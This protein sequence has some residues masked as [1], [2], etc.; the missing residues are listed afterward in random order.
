M[1]RLLALLV[2]LAMLL[3]GTPRAVVVAR[4]Q[5]AAI[6]ATPAAIPGFT[7][8]RNDAV[9]QFPDGITFSID[10][11][12]S[13]PIA[14]VELLYHAPGIETLSM[15]VPPITPGETRLTVEHPVDL[16][17][18]QLPPG[19]DVIY[20]WRIIDAEGNVTQ[21]DEQTL[22]WEDNRYDWTE[23]AGPRV[24]VYAY[25]ASPEFQQAILDSAERT[26]DKLN[27]AYGFLPTQPIR[28][29]AYATKD[30]L[31]GAL[32]PN[33]EPWIAGEAQP[34]LFLIRAILP[35]D[36]L[37][38]VDRVV[39]HEITHQVSYQV[40]KN[41]FNYPPLWLNEG[42]AV[43]WQETGRDRFYTHALQIAKDGNVPPLRTLNGDFAYDSEGALGSYAL[44]LSAVIYILDTYG[45]EGMANLLNVFREGITYDDA[46]EQG[47]GVSFDELDAGWHAYIK[48]KA[49]TL[50][51]SGS[52]RFGDTEPPQNTP[53]GS[54][55]EF[56]ATSAG[57]LILGLV[58]LIALAAGVI[59]R[60]RRKPATADDDEADDLSPGPRWRDWPESV[61]LPGRQAR[62]PSHP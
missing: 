7:I 25:D 21:T 13:T 20:S 41:P 53:G 22:L 30:D 58:V 45:D 48:E 2:I 44:S 28:I 1:N 35:P 39:P 15:E 36:D 38:E 49:D 3:G 4:A 23:L 52:T 9:S 43:Y 12:S 31:Y 18:G 33:S 6:V 51:A 37:R 46:I 34:S 14:R 24:T 59:S 50:L 10:A 26:I 17:S 55:W 11:E 60:L 27:N 54:L 16:R 29:W 8:L 5:D 56:L 47:L 62:L 57:S 61:E 40:T 19:I 32:A 42:L